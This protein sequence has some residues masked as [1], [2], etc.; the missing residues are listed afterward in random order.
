MN[1]IE[2][3][4]YSDGCRIEK[5]INEK[6][7]ITIENYFNVKGALESTF[8]Y[9]YNTEGICLEEAE[10]DGEGQI[11]SKT[12]YNYDLTSNNIER[13]DYKDGKPVKKSTEIFNV[14]KKSN[15]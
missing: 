3:E 10:Y 12:N 11:T 15:K 9:A 4:Y 6:G 14:E 5:T 7:E 2:N 8:T 1:K 13:T